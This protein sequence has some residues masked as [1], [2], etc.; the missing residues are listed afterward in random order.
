ME[1]EPGKGFDAESYIKT[2]EKGLIP[3]YEYDQ[4]FQQDNAPIH[5]AKLTES[6]FEDRRIGRMN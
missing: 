4:I 3:I 2:L 1:K 6:W 5:K